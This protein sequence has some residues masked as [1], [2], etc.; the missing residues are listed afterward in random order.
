MTTEWGKWGLLALT[1]CFCLS[2]LPGC[3]PE[4]YGATMAQDNTMQKKKVIDGRRELMRNNSVHFKDL[5]QK[6][7]GGQL[8]QIAVNAHTI[9]INARHIPSLFPAGT[10]GTSEIKSRAKPEIWQDWNGFKAAAKQLEDAATDLM[11]LTKNAGKMG[12]TSAQVNTAAK[13]IGGACKNCHKK[14][15]VPK[16]KK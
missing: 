6:A 11:Q 4:Q 5:R 13:A 15:R 7:K 1:T 12:V 10:L 9:A 2:A 8:T 14:F 16:K 3:M